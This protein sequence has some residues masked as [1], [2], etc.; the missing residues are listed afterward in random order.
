M[1]I[2]CR[3]DQRILLGKHAIHPEHKICPLHQ[4]LPAVRQWG[5]VLCQ[6]RLPGI[7][8]GKNRPGCWR[9]NAV[10]QLVMQLGAGLEAGTAPLRL[11]LFVYPQQIAGVIPEEVGQDT[12]CT[13]DR[14]GQFHYLWP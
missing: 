5:A 8:E 14:R 12:N 1:G 6:L 13:G 3:T 7:E 4:V 11:A 10:Q 2:P 9:G